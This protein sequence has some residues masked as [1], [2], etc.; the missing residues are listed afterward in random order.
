MEALL[1]VLG[2]LGVVLVARGLEHDDL[3]LFI[4]GVAV[5]IGGTAWALAIIV[6]GTI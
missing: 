1:F 2:V 6:A 5:L 3:I 4:C